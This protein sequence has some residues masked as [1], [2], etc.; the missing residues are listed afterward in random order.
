MPL[1]LYP[2][3]ARKLIADPVMAAEVLM[4]IKLDTYQGAKLKN[5]WF[6]PDVMDHSGVSTGKTELLFIWA[7]LRLTLLPLPMLDKGRIVSIYYIALGTA[8]QTF[9]P[10]VEEYLRRSRFYENE[11]ARQ[12][13]GAF[14]RQF[15]NVIIIEY[16][17]GGRLQLPAGDFMKDSENQASMRFND[18]ALDEGALIETKGKGVDEQLLQR[19]TMESFNPNHPIHCNHTLFLGHAEDPSHPYHARYLAMRREYR[20]RCSQDSLTITASYKDYSPEYHKK[21]G[22]PVQRRHEK[23]IARG[24]DPALLAQI[25]EGLWKRGSRG[26]YPG[27]LRDGIESAEAVPM[28]RRQRPGT[29]FSLGWD[30]AT[31]LK[32][33]ADFNAGVVWAADEMDANHYRPGCPGHMALGKKLW[34][35]RPVHALYGLGWDVDQ[36]SG[37]IHLLD[38]A[39]GFDLLALDSQGGGADVYKKLRERRQFINN[40]WKEVPS[41]LCTPGDAHAWPGARP[42]VYFYDRGDPLFRAEFGQHWVKDQSGPS[43]YMHRQVTA[44]MRAQEIAWPAPQDGRPVEGKLPPVL[45]D[46]QRDLD[47]T[48]AQYG[49]IAVRLDKKGKPQISQAGFQ[50]FTHTG[51]KD[52]AMASSYGLLAL[53]SRLKRLSGVDTGKQEAE[54]TGLEIYQ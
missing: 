54:D 15:K 40:A 14:Y 41:G 3:T 53:I 1:T 26:L 30:S 38:S 45:L 22:V 39:F 32:K 2:S 31:T 4:G 52:G 44:M 24:K 21:Y 25:Y 7:H 11:I 33:G 42:I 51:K 20:R 43:D 17:N 35:V 48:L 18:L 13:G 6:A 5:W 36:R 16:R 19:N 12:R 27:H 46:L 28:L 47:V 37:V 50:Q 23:D 9:L 49:N 29:I 8:Q 34:F 10:K